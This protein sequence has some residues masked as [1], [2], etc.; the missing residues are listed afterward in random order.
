MLK[1]VTKIKIDKD[2]DEQLVER[3][4]EM[5][6]DAKSGELIALLSVQKY[7]D[8]EVTCLYTQEAD[9]EMVG[10][11]EALKHIWFNVWYGTE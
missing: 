7:S 2:P 1:E 10:A 6:A 11:I 9:H 5:L 8:E 3:L 4:E